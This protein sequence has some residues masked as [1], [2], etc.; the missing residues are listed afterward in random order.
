[1]GNKFSVGDKVMIGVG[2]KFYCM[3]DISNP[4]D[5]IGTVTYVSDDSRLSIHVRWD[6]KYHNG[7]DI[8]NSYDDEDLVFAFAHVNKQFGKLDN[9]VFE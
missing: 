1:M 9:F 8:T 3:N 2:T 4:R 7:I 5:T 6:A